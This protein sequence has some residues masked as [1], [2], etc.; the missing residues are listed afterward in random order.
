[1]SLSCRVFLAVARYWSKIADLNLP[2]LYLTPLLGVISLEFRRNFWH[3]NTRVP[4]QYGVICAILGLAIF[5]E[6][7]LVTDRQTDRQTDTRD[8]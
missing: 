4:E 3:Q 7:R 8:S 6:L 5:V 1:M 2:R